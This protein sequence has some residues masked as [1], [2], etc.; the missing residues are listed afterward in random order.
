MTGTY[1][2]L[3]TDSLVQSMMKIEQLKMDRQ[4]RSLTTMTWKQ[5]T[6]NS[7]NTDLK[8]FMQDYVSVLG[9]NSMMKSGNYVNYTATVSGDNASAVTVSGTSQAFEG[10]VSIDQIIQLATASKATSTGGVSN[11]GEL[12][13]TNST[14]L[15]QLDFANKLQFVDDEIS[16]AINGEE[17]TFKSTD[18]LQTMLNVVNSS[19]AGVNMSYSRLTDSFTVASKETGADGEVEILNLKGNAFGVDSAFGISNGTYGGGENAKVKINGITVERSS[20]N[21]E[22]DG[23]NYTLN[24]TTEA[25][26][27]PIQVT[28]KQDVSKA[29][30][31]IKQFIEGYNTLLNKLNELVT[32]RKTTKEKNYTPLTE[33]EKSSMT[34]DQIEQWETIAKKGLMYNDS[35]LRSLVSNMRSAFYDTIESAGISMSELGL[36]TGDYDKLGELTLDEDTLRAALEKNP[37]QVMSAFM[38]MSDSEDAATAYKENGIMYRL[39]TIM[40]DYMKGTAQTSLDTIE[41]KIYNASKKITEMEERMLEIEERYYLKYAALE[42]AMSQ[43][44]SQS[45][46]LTSMLSSS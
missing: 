13:E 46:W 26:D 30:D 25:G 5:E 14:R 17:F 19:G 43:L 22:I 27:D 18:S 40:N 41:T 36:R 44:S 12:S 45:D 28:L 3:D 8:A 38:N 42:E 7:V 35:G 2:G 11:N 16:F 4:T 10:T 1:S 6:Y 9:K 31:S 21:F 32:T 15:S 24:R 23:V 33:E 39:N 34:E 29:V 37:H 20:N